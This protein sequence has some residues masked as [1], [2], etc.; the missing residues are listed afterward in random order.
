MDLASVGIG[1]VSAVDS[2]AGTCLG[3]PAFAEVVK[4]DAGEPR[5]DAA[6]QRRSGGVQALYERTR[7]SD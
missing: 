5:G 7:R 3:A 6:A 1:A 2:A 4:D